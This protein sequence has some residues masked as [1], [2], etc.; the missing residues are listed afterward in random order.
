MDTLIR[1]LHPF[2]LIIEANM[3]VPNIGEMWRPSGA[4]RDIL[5][6]CVQRNI[7]EKN[8]ELTTI[9]K[10]ERLNDGVRIYRDS[11]DITRWVF[12]Q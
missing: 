11:S 8:D 10:F 2:F 12:V 9:Y 7:I 1:C 3:R 4:K 5:Y 6:L